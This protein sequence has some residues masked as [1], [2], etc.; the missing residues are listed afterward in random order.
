MRLEITSLI[1]GLP[2][3]QLSETSEQVTSDRGD[4]LLR[5][6][7]NHS[8]HEW[9]KSPMYKRLKSL[10]SSLKQTDPKKEVDAV[11]QLRARNSPSYTATA[12]GNPGQTGWRSGGAVRAQ[13]DLTL[14]GGPGRLPEYRRLGTRSGPPGPQRRSSRSGRPKRPIGTN[15]RMRSARCLY[16][17]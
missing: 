13:G 15:H 4:H 10:Y 2:T 5:R 6:E 14:H 11:L 1:L 9:S 16:K 3:I 12:R 17:Y 8:D 7:G